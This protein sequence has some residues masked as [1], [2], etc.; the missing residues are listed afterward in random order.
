MDET[1][2]EATSWHKK[3]DSDRRFLVNDPS[4]TRALVSWIG[5]ADLAAPGGDAPGPV[6]SALR[7]GAFDHATLLSD[8][9][10]ERIEPYTAWLRT[11]T[12]TPFDVRPARLAGPTH[13]GDIYVAATTAVADLL[14]RFRGNVELTFHLSP[15]TPAVAAVWIILAKTRFPAEL[16][17]S[18]REHGVRVAS[19][20]FDIAAEFIPDLLSGPDRRLRERSAEPPPA[21]P[22]FDDIVHRSA[23][24]RRLLA[25]AKRAAPRSV[26]VLI[27]GESGTGKELLARAIHQASPRRAARFVPVN[28]G[29]IPTDL[30]ESELFGHVKG[31][32]TGA[33]ADRPGLFEAAD[34]GTLFL[35]ELGELPKAAQVKLL[36]VIQEGEVVRV[37]STRETKVDVRLI[38]ATNRSLVEEVTR[39][40]FREDLFFRLAVAVLRI[41]PLRERPG[42]LGLLID[43]LLERIDVESAGEP[44]YVPKRLS[45]AARNVLLGYEWPGNIRELQ[46]TLRRI[47][48]WAENPTIEADDVREA[49]LPV[50]EA[51]VNRILGRPLGAGFSLPD[52]LATVAR[53]YLERSM[54]EAHGNKSEAARLVGLKSYQTLSNWLDRYGVGAGTE[55]AGTGGR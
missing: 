21:A 42:D 28:C 22:E 48:V 1:Q 16:I 36:R 45:P 34:G 37:G 12:N 50:G 40:A 26:P 19:V 38:A 10:A 8:F 49:L 14:E 6:A 7:W 31:A 17:E 35:D 3:H 43:R 44:G 18:S 52:L 32:F 30:V 20:P 54:A 11:R 39:G 5:N 47:S 2:P 25:R 27:E 23:P 53:H 29:A 41:P 15:G 13:F 33:A 4:P 24:M 51:A 55:V 9:P 46:N